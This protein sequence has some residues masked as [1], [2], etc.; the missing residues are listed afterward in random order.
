MSANYRSKAKESFKTRIRFFKF[1]CVL[2]EKVFSKEEFLNYQLDLDFINQVTAQYYQWLSNDKMVGFINAPT[3]EEV[4]KML[5]QL[6]GDL[7]NDWFDEYYIE[8]QKQFPISEFENLVKVETC[9]Y[10]GINLEEINEL[11]EAQQIHK[12]YE[13]GYSMEIDR[14]FPNLEYTTG[15]CVPACY[16]CNNAKT[17]EFTATEFKLIGEL[18]GKTLKARLKK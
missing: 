2:N 9:H 1:E 10:C 12:K 3:V 13:R 16:W 7:V 4:Y 14:K 15:N 17:D 6:P 18:I 11:A 8:F 5:L